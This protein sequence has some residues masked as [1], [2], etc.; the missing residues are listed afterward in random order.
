MATKIYVVYYSTYGHVA[1]LAE[2]IKKGASSVEGVEVKLWQ[3]PESLSEEAFAKIGAPAKKKQDVPIITPAELL[4]EADGLLF[5][6]PTRFGMMPAQLR[7]T[8]GARRS[9]QASRQVSSAPPG[10]RAVARKLPC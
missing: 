1:T 10:A 4:V 8:C 5:G 3:V 7:A 2:E 6:F 9:S